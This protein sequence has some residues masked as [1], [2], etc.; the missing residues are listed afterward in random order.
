MDFAIELT[1]I[2]IVAAVGAAFFF[3]TILMVIDLRAKHRRMGILYVILAVVGGIA[4]FT[5]FCY[6]YKP[7]A[8]IDGVG[9]KKLLD[10]TLLALIP[11]CIFLSGLGYWL[12]LIMNVGAVKRLKR[13][14]CSFKII[15]DIKSGPQKSVTPSELKKYQ[16]KFEKNDVIDE[17]IR[18]GKL[19]EAKNYLEKTYR[20]SGRF[21]DQRAVE[22][23]ENYIKIIEKEITF[24][25]ESIGLGSRL[26]EFS[27][28]EKWDKDLMADPRYRGFMKRANLIRD[29]A[30]EPEDTDEDKVN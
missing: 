12:F 9:F 10:I 4:G 3:T 15:E 16:A 28:K 25:E 6:W 24:V 13:R 8:I 29:D 27:Y 26:P 1:N 23:Y 22:Q 18:R 17:L 30:A 2:I 7:R 14:R 5:L 20:L 19:V 11:A 21:T